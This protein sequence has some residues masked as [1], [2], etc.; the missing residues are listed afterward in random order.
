MNTGRSTLLGW[1][2]LIAGAGVSF[3]YA[4]RGIDQRR[5][6]QDVAGVRPSAIKDW[7]QRIEQP[8]PQRPNVDHTSHYSKTASPEDSYKAA[9][10]KKKTEDDTSHA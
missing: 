1:G 7:R 8:P 2:A 6:E 9:L 10:P 5:R 3:Y 4:K